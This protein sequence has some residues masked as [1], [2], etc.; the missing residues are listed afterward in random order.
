MK[1]PLNRVIAFAGHYISIGS[2]L[3]AAWI[4][5]KLNLLGFH[6]LSVDSLAQSIAGGATFVLTTGLAHLGQSKW[7]TGHH[8]ELEGIVAQQVA[9]VSAAV[10]PPPDATGVDPEHDELMAAG[11]DLPS[12]EEEFADAPD[13]D[14]RAAPDVPPGDTSS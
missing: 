7:L 2:G 3:I 14:G 8:I 6:E 10:L 11:D 5:A 1:I 13:Q 4:V 9:A 12:D